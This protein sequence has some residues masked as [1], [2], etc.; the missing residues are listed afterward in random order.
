MFL[1]DYGNGSAYP[2]DCVHIC[3]CL[4]MCFMAYYFC[5][6][7]RCGWCQILAIPRSWRHHEKD[8]KSGCHSVSTSATDA[9]GKMPTRNVKIQENYLI[10]CAKQ[11][12]KQSTSIN[13]MNNIVVIILTW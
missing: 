6:M 8:V 3:A 4:C 9:A 5:I 2:T 10:F 13:H 11:T 12:L 7:Y 1:V